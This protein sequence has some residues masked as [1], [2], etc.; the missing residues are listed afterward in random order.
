MYQLD[1]SDIYN[2][3]LF[4][5]HGYCPETRYNHNICILSPSLTD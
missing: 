1:V 3:S 2:H 4:E 5:D